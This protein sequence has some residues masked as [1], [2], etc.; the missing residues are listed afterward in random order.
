M[1][2]ARFIHAYGSSAR[3]II[4][5]YGSNLHRIHVCSAITSWRE[6]ALA[7]SEDSAAAIRPAADRVIPAEARECPVLASAAECLDLAGD[8][9]AG[10]R[11]AAPSDGPVSGAALP[12]VHHPSSSPFALI[13]QVANN[14]RGVMFRGRVLQSQVLVMKLTGSVGMKD[15]EHAID[16]RLRSGALPLHAWAV[17]RA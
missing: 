2:N 3:D 11:E 7:A 8:F 1:S 16:S 17:S 9:R 10:L 14:F 13:V 6:V 4:G 12:S 5:P 15:C